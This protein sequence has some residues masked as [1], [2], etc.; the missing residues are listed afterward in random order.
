[1]NAAVSFSLPAKK[2]KHT[3][4]KSI[5]NLAGAVMTVKFSLPT[6]KNV[7]NAA[8][9]FFLLAKKQKNIAV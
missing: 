9:S 1:V 4:G 7:V 5:P 6:R 8:D 3:A 2:Q